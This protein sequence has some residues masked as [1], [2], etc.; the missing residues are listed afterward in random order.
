MVARTKAEVLT[1]AEGGRADRTAAIVAQAD[2]SGAIDDDGNVS[3]A[4]VR[5][6]VTKVLESY[7]EWK[8]TPGTPPKSGGE[9]T[10]GG[11]TGS[12]FTKSQVESMKPEEL[13]AKLPE[14][15]KAMAEGRFVYDK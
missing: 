3:E 14:I 8:Q 15:E 9:I 12:T 10:P 5:A 2:L 6:A 13:Q 1:I 7:P 11:G 4:V